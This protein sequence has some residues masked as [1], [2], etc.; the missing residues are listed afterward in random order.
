MFLD[1]NKSF[2]IHKNFSPMP[3]KISNKL[4]SMHL[5]LRISMLDVKNIIDVKIGNT[6]L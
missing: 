4:V 5:N 2:E 3:R 1:F 6:Y